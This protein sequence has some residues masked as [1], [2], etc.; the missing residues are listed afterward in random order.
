MLKAIIFLLVT[1]F[2]ISSSTKV[3]L[4]LGAGGARAAFQVGALKRICQTNPNSWDMIVATSTGAV[5]GAIL[6]QFNKNEQ[7]SKGLPAVVSFWESIKSQNDLFEPYSWFSFG[8]CLNS[9]NFLSLGKGWYESGGMCSS[10]PAKKKLSNSINEQRIRSSNM[11]FHFVLSS[12]QDS[13]NP[14][15]YDKTASS[16]TLR[17]LASASVSFLLPPIL[18]DGH[19]YTDGGAFTDL[20]ITKAIELG[21]G[22]IRAVVINPLNGNYDADIL[23]AERDERIG[24]VSLQY[25]YNVVHRNAFVVSD[26]RYACT[27]HGNV[28]VTAIVATKYLG[29]VTDFE[30]SH[31][32]EATDHGYQ[33][34]VNVG[35]ID[36]CRYN[37]ISPLPLRKELSSS[38]STSQKSPSSSGQ[39]IWMT[40]GIALGGVVFGGL[41]VFTAFAKKL[42]AINEHAFVAV[43]RQ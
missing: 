10:K 23:Q 35:F 1:L 26:L 8:K 34:A 29:E 19:F 14:V 16:L 22:L 3:A 5:N 33:Q 13:E 20:P 12:F 39:S 11:G 9:V 31:I 42:K 28:P 27:K 21:A 40:I 4:V 7:C 38:D 25:I 17:L 43:P 18:I 37:S 32:R 6:A 15:W 24:P 36:L 41:V 2:G 30:P